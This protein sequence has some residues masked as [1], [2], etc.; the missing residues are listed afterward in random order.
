MALVAGFSIIEVKE[1]CLDISGVAVFSIDPT[2]FI[3]DFFFSL[4]FAYFIVFTN[5]DAMYVIVIFDLE[6]LQFT[7][8]TILLPDKDYT[9]L[10]NY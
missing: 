10:L 7:S 3:A 4:S 8:I 1:G 2:N 9:F 5:R 6:G